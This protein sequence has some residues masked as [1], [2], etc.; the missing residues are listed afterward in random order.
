MPDLCRIMTAIPQTR[1]PLFAN[2]LCML[3]MLTW[4]AGLPAA[5][6]LIGKVPPL[7]LTAARMTMA[8]AVL[9]PMWVLADGWATLRRAEWRK[10]IAIGGLTI[11]LGAV[12]LVIGQSMTGSVTVAIISAT[13]PLIGIAIEV[14]LD[15]RKLTLTLLAGL[16]LALVGGVM[17]L[18]SGAASLNL[19]L[20]ALFC[21]GSVVVFAFG[22]RLTITAFPDL[23]A[24]GRTTI[25]L[26]GAAILITTA[27]LGHWALG[28]DAPDLAPLG[29]REFGA[30]A[31]FSVGG[32]AISQV[33]WIISVGQIGIGM[34]SLHIN[35]TPFYVM[36]ILFLFGAP[37]VWPQAIAAAIVGL[38]VV[39]A[40]G[41]FFPNRT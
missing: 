24:L 37:W 39:I 32:L 9:L 33:L 21:F 4:A 34:A 25:T 16:A 13:L 23:S 35:A 30:L 41:V 20:G 14:A 10:G 36:L 18:G 27:A 31:V 3:S 6:V 8:A 17:A 5:D 1:A 40:Q 29:W 11:G 22:S 19:G 12:L 7:P 2:L 38:G 28:A 15:G 26:T